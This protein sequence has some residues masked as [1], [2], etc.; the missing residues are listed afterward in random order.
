M[1]PHWPRALAS[2]VGFSFSSS[3]PFFPSSSSP[4]SSTSS[5]STTT[6]STTTT[7]ALASPVAC[8]LQGPFS[9]A[10]GKGG[11]DKQCSHPPSLMDSCSDASVV[12][13]QYQACPD[14]AGSESLGES[15]VM[16]VC[17]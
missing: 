15:W 8:P 12:Q 13:I 1:G 17:R 9:L 14:V 11:A 16:V 10:Y 6:S 5:S 2:Y 4:S 7:R 3:F